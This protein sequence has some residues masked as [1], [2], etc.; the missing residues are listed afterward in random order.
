MLLPCRRLHRKAEVLR[1]SPAPSPARAIHGT[2][3]PPISSQ[4]RNRLQCAFA[5]GHASHARRLSPSRQAARRILRRAAVP[6]LLGRH[7]LRLL[8]RRRVLRVAQRHLHIHPLAPPEDRH[9]HRI[10][11]MLRIHRGGQVLRRW[12]SPARR[13]PRSGRRPASPAYC[14]HRRAR[15][16]PCSPAFSAAP[17]GNTRSISTP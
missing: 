14:P 3:C 16:P 10:A 11:R 9:R 8:P 2:G 4:H 12:Q 7:H 17:P 13:T 5:I 6:P 1:S 15:V